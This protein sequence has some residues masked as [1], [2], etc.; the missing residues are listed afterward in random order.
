MNYNELSADQKVKITTL[1]ELKN[2]GYQP[3]SI[4]DE[5]R[6]NLIQVKRSGQNIFEGIWGY[7]DTVIPDV[8]RAILSRHNINFLGLRGR[9][10][11]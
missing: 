3:K 2:A 1:G 11:L 7:E 10:Y 5:L 8:E 4:K 9:K 6:A